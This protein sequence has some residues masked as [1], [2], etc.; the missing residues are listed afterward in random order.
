[1]TKERRRV[2]PSQGDLREVTRY[3]AECA[4]AVLKIFEHAYP[5]DRRSRAA[6]EA[7]RTFPGG[8]SDSSTPLKRRSGGLQHLV[9]STKRGGARR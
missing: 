3:A 2:V 5:A 1:M 8:R 6:I 7:A 9:R 4:Q